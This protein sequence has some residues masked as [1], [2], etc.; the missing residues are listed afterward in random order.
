MKN[1]WKCLAISFIGAGTGLM[2]YC[3]SFYMKSYEEN[4]R[5]REQYEA[6]REA[7]MNVEEN[8]GRS[9]KKEEADDGVKSKKEMEIRESFGISWENLW[10]INSDIKGWIM[11]P[12]ADISY[13]IV[14]G[15]DDDFYLTHSIEGKEDPFGSIFLGCGHD[16]S[17]LNSHSL[18]YGHN[19]EGHMM[20]ANLNCYENREFLEECPEFIITTPERQFVYEIFSVEQAGEN[21]PAFGYGYETGSKEYK[22]QLETLKRNSIYETGIF[23]NEQQKMVTLVTC[24]SRL[25]ADVRMAI[26]G[27]CTRVLRETSG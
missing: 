24:N 15:K 10:K 8:D 3:G 26:H 5:T 9:K 17:F 4:R 13:P 6:I 20:F 22:A 2:V 16:E 27:I 11:V 21:S 19:M 7:C 12:G 25:E 23:P 14:Q 18:I 1:I